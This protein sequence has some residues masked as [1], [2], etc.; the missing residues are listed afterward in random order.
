MRG[1]TQNILDFYDVL[2][3]V[4]NKS[5]NSCNNVKEGKILLVSY[6]FNCNNFK[7]RRL[8][9]ITYLSNLFYDM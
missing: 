8:I 6:L 5:F 2:F 7:N 9:F 3:K 4:W 1:S